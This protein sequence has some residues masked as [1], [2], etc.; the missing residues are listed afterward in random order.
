MRLTEILS[1]DGSKIYIQ[2]DEEESDEL[3]AVGDFDNIYERT[4]Q[5]R[6]SM[7]STIRGYSQTV[8]SS[9]EEG[10]ADLTAPS[11]LTLE[12][13]LQVG[14]ETGIPFIAKGTSQANIK[15]TVEWNLNNKNQS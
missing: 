2:Y 8:L 11:K 10:M 7:T 12:F 5:F 3:Q 9:V 1:P 13:G 4:E 15:V 6:K 14:G